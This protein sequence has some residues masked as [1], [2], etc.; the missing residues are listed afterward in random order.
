V[1]AARPEPVHIDDYAHPRFTDDVRA[2]RDSVGPLATELD[3][4]SGPVMEQAA[5][6][7]RLDDFGD[8]TFV[9]RLDVWLTAMRDEADLDSFGVLSTHAMA[10]QLL[11]NRLLITDLLARHPEIRDIPI[12]RPIVIAG[13]P[14]TGTTHL[15]NLLS[16][17]PNLRSLP[18]WESLEPVPGVD[19][20]PAPGEPDPRFART[21]MGVDFVDASMP[22]F[23]RMHEMTVDHV[24]EEI[25]LLAIDFSS[26][27]FETLGLIPSWRDFYLGHDQTPHYEYLKTVLQVLTYLRGGARWVLKSPQHT[28]QLRALSTVFPDATF[29]LTHRDPVRVTTS[30]V[31]MITYCARMGCA[32]PDPVRYGAYWSARIEDLLLGCVRDRDVLPESQTVDVRFHEFMADDI[33]T[34][35]QI[36]SVADQPFTDDTRA[37][38]D[39]F[40]A[41]HPRGRHGTVVYDLADFG[42]SAEE[43]RRALRPYVE[44]FDV[45]EE[46]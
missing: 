45:E 10:L 29:V 5:S 41:T 33:A 25:H 38:M 8:P 2:I 22:H 12:D 20:H 9:P 11:K 46:A 6:E 39:A 26:M 3:L 4:E 30:M 24:H 35:E 37:A 16:T 17:D 44:R 34:V 31:T 21:Q 40:M 1:S 43:R 28:E 23:E 19:D 13:L 7:C 36:Y 18:Y 14:R 42:L 32:E 15:H 27:F